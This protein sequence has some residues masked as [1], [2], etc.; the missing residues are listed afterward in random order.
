MAD[1]EHQEVSVEVG[2]PPVRLMPRHPLGGRPAIDGTDLVELGT[3]AGAI[4]VERSEMI[5]MMHK[6]Q[7]M[8]M[9]SSLQTLPLVM[10]MVKQANQAR[11]NSVI[12]KVRMMPEFGGGIMRT[13]N[14]NGNVSL[15]SRIDV[16]NIL[17]AAMVEAPPG[18]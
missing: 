14:G 5:R 7:E 15:V 12:Q 18:M 9:T 1:S 11:I 16:I 3:M 17:T 8:A 10:E 4:G 2:S 13:L 6:L